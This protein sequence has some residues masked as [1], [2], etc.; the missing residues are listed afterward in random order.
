MGPG[1][2]QS[3]RVGLFGSRTWASA[4]HKPSAGDSHARSHTGP[5]TGL[6]PPHATVALR[7]NGSCG[8]HAWMPVDLDALSPEERRARFRKREAQL[9]GKEEQQP[10]LLDNFDLERYKQF[11]TKK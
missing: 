8:Q 1:P 5:V 3:Y 7:R 6:G 11:W 10:E 2:A 9:R 4:D